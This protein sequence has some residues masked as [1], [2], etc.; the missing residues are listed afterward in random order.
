MLPLQSSSLVPTYWTAAYIEGMHYI[1]TTAT[2]L[3]SV[4]SAKR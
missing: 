2:L 4:L 1:I 3:V